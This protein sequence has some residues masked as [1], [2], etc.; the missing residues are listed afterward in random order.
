MK[1]HLVSVEQDGRVKLFEQEEWKRSIR[2]AHPTAHFY[3]AVEQ[4]VESLVAYD[5]KDASK[6]YGTWRRT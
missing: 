6:E 5:S 4:G 1:T 3:I 2:A